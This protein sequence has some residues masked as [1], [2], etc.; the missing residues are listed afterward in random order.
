VRRVL[1]I[2]RLL[3][4]AGVLLALSAATYGVHTVQLRRQTS[5][6]KDQAAKAEETAATDPAMSDKAMDLYKQYLKFQKTDEPAYRR[7]A[8][9][10]TARAKA[11]PKKVPEAADV[12]EGLLRQ[13]RDSPAERKQLVELYVKLGKLTSARQHLQMLDC[14]GDADLLEKSALCELGLGGDQMTAV[15]M[16]DAAV[17]TKKAP[18]R[19]FE[20]LFAILHARRAAPDPGYTPETYLR[21]LQ[22][23]EPYRSDIETRVTAARQLLRTN[24][25]AARDEIAYILTKMPGGATSA[26]GLLAAAESELGEIKTPEAVRPQ[27]AKA[28]NH[29]EVASTAHP[30]DVRVGLLLARVLTEQGESGK[31]VEILK[32]SAAALGETDDQ[33]LTL[34]DRLLDLRDEDLAVKLIERVEANDVDRGRVAK[35]FRGRLALNRGEYPQ[36]RALLDEVAPLVAPVPE[37]HKR[38]MAGLGRCYEVIQNPDKQ[39]ECYA[40]ALRDDRHYL[41]AFVGEADA[42]MRLGRFRDALPRFQ[43]LVNGYKIDA[44]RGTLARLEL[45]AVLRQPAGSR[46]WAPFDESLGPVE[47]RTAELHLLHAES[48]AARGDAEKAAAVLLPVVKGDPKNTAAWVTLVRIQALGRP[49]TMLDRLAEVEKATGDTVDLRL[50]RAVLVVARA[51]KPTPDDFRALAAGDTAFGPA[52]RNRLWRGLGEAAYRAAGAAPEADAG[53]L[54]GLA[55]DCFQT[56]A[57]LDKTDLVARAV[58]LDV[59]LAAGRPDVTA[60]ALAGIAEAEGPGGPIGTLGR[61]IL[62]LPAVRKI[63][64][65]AA[66]AAAVQDLRDQTLR[67][68]AQR[69]GWGRVYVTLAR[70]DELEG[71]NDAALTNYTEAIAKGEREEYVIRRAVDLHRERKQED[72]AAALLNSLH[73]EMRLPDDLERFRAIKDLLARDIPKGER[74]TI[75]RVAPAD[76]KDWRILLLRGSLLAAIG[77]DAD[78]QGAFLRAVELAETVPDTWGALVGNFVRLGKIDD[79]RRAIA[80]AEGKLKTNPAKPDDL[81]AQAAQAELVTTLAACYELIGDRPAAEARYREAARLAP[82]ELNPTRQLVLF[83]QRTGKVAEA[84]E[85]LR[86]LTDDP[87]QD[88]A[89]WARRHLALTLMARS[90]A[91]HNRAAAAALIERNVAASRTDPEDVKAKAVVQT[92][93]PA[94]RDEGMKTLKE[95]AKWGDLTPDEFYLLGRLHFDQGK[96]FDSV[97]FFEKAARPRPGLTPEHLSGLTRIY[98]GINKLG[99]ARATVA[100][101]KAMAPTSWDA[102]RDEARVLHKEAA[103]AKAAGDEAKDKKLT[104]EARDLVLKFPGGDAGDAAADRTGPLLEELGFAADAEALYAKLLA[105]G[106]GTSPHLPLARFYVGRKRAADAIALA[107]A[108][109]ATTPVVVTAGLLTGAIRARNPGPDVARGVLAWLDAKLAQPRPKWEELALLAAKAEFLDATGKY[110]EAVAAYELAIRRAKE[111]GPDDARRVDAGLWVNNMCMLL[112]LLRPAEAD[113]VI[114]LMTEQLLIR[115]PAPAFLDTRALAYV[116]KGGKTDEAINDLKLALIQRHRPEY[117]FHLAWAYDLTS[118]KRNLRNGPLAEARE[119]KLSL[120]DLHPLEARKFAELTTAK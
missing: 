64:D 31:A 71:L 41:P 5:V 73:T 88:L 52:D 102:T 85:M 81:P 95:F 106:K 12:L 90:D 48:L 53:P 80:Q 87:A 37:F 16:L 28:R 62:R 21:I 107:R 6:L 36:A 8:A 3:I 74:P 84:V 117:L 119:L 104:D 103:A 94:T 99:P 113:R 50:A 108:H 70:L 89:R 4:V 54:R 92:V 38:A 13:F 59:G 18:A 76:T 111:A 51:K 40:A 11:D 98:L 110:D 72:Q 25:L 15:K 44:F 17:A 39:L 33:F 77:E 67:A 86:R 65:K 30:R 100:R 91:Y 26:D 56:A 96:I 20:Q 66:R 29:L 1:S 79:A 58:L 93:D 61:V 120:D 57:E 78:A 112:V 115:G 114:D 32:A 23:T 34:V 47:G 19:V 69:P 97:D 2:K 7:Y 35:Y 45:R 55:I 42:L 83:H 43:S 27:L 109:E 105:A 82:R 10:A 118:D 63:D 24:P 75:D 116:I 49:E 46:N 60:A 14:Q 101:L 22:E 68:K 9:L